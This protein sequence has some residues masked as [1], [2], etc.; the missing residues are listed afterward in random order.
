MDAHTQNRRC[1]YRNV[2]HKT[3]VTLTLTIGNDRNRFTPMQNVIH[4]SQ[5]EQRAHFLVTIV[6]IVLFFQFFY[7]LCKFIFF[8][9]CNLLL[10]RFYIG[11]FEVQFSALSL[12][13]LFNI[14]PLKMEFTCRIW[15]IYLFIYV[16]FLHAISESVSFSAIPM[17]ALCN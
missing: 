4:V 1:H 16:K 9:F 15:F 2:M 17:T 7:S 12:S 14:F 11:H 8:E 13:H 3:T 6:Y 5:S 10:P